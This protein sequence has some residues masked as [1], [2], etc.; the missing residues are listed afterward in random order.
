MIGR[1][2]FPI[3]ITEEATGSS[4]YWICWPLPAQR[5]SMSFGKRVGQAVPVLGREGE[6]PADLNHRCIPH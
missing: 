5:S 1:A 2:M 3:P 6:A 4:T